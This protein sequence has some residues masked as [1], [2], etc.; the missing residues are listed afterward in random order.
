MQVYN[1]EQ[2]IGSVVWATSE[3]GGGPDVGILLRLSE[4]DFLWC[5]EITRKEAD[6]AGISDAGWHLVL[7]RG[8]DSQVVA[9][10]PD[11]YAGSDLMEAITAVVRIEPTE[12]H[13]AG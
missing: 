4:A 5:G 13:D 9:Q 10:V 3:E 8:A 2:P 1:P 11:Q 12:P 6:A 7:H